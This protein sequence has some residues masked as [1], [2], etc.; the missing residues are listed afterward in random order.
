MTPNKIQN[1]PYYGAR[2]SV[3]LFY[4]SSFFYHVTGS[5]THMCVGASNELHKESHTGIKRYRVKLWGQ[6][7]APFYSASVLPLFLVCNSVA[8][9]VTKQN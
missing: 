5:N 1:N 6:F 9:D 8:N 3:Y 7:H 2:T 4:F